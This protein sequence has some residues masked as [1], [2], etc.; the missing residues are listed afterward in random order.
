[1]SICIIEHHELNMSVMM[2]VQNKPL[3]DSL[4]TM[5]RFINDT[6]FKNLLNKPF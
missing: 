2:A 5:T 4:T 6:K 1:L 3:E